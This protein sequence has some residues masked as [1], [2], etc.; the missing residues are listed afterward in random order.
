[1][2]SRY[3]SREIDV[4]PIDLEEY[5][6][7][8]IGKLNNPQTAIPEIAKDTELMVL[9]DRAVRCVPTSH[10]LVRWDSRGEWHLSSK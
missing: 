5:I 8:E 2:S 6:P 10:T 4:P 7:S 9:I 3:I 1:M